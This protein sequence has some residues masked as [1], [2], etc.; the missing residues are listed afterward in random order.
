MDHIESLDSSRKSAIAEAFSKA[1]YCYDK[2]AQF[3]RDVGSLMLNSLPH[4]LRGLQILDI[5]CGT[6]YF[7]HILAERGATVIAADLSSAM[8]SQAKVRCGDAV[9]SYVQADAER[10]PFNDAQ[11]DLVFSSL[12]LQWCNDLSIPLRELQRVTKLGGEIHF[13]TLLEGSL[14][15]LKSAWSQIDSYQHVNQFLSEKQVNIALTQ[16]GSVNHQLD[17]CQIELW[18]PSSFEL[19]RDLK[20]IG[21]TYVGKRS[22]GLTKKST[23][24]RVEA[25]YQ[26]FKHENNLLPVTYQVGLG[27]ISL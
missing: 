14:F 7:S 4:D 8:L 1:A 23:L 10:L 6:G 5:G 12:A 15:E 2:H 25:A 3:Q 16:S 20:G 17:L 24:I 27:T 19:M 9:Y 11:F 26:R 21:A 18:Y 13:S 22:P